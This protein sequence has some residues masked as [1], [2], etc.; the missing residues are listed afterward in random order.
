MRTTFARPTMTHYCRAC[1]RCKR[2]CKDCRTRVKSGPDFKVNHGKCQTIC[3][4]PYTT[5]R[6]TCRSLCHDEEKCP[7]CDDKCEVRCSHSE[8]P[9][10]C[11]ELRQPRAEKRYVSV[12][13]HSACTVP[14]S[15]P[16]SRRCEGKVVCD[17]QCKPISVVL[18]SIISNHEQVQALAGSDALQR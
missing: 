13:S 10:K 3:G 15:V 6:H 8:Y 1:H 5:C 17:H 12:C 7:P 9:K 18:Q 11:E 14:C 16:C 2:K 4:R